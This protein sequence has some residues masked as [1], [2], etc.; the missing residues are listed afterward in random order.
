P[1]R[2]DAGGRGR[3]AR[4]HVE[5]RV[6][7]LERA[8]AG[9][10]RG[11]AAGPAHRRENMFRPPPHADGGRPLGHPAR[12]REAGAAAGQRPPSG[13][14]A[15]PPAIVAAPDLHERPAG[16]LTP[17]TVRPPFARRPAPH[18]RYSPYFEIAFSYVGASFVGTRC[19]TSSSVAP[20][21]T[22]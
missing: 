19:L 9:A 11:E 1:S 13:G 16:Q 14:H 3:A 6:G 4:H 2:S 20:A 12:V 22:S 10:Q 5:R 15:A 7:A 8:R 21:A 18:G 17:P